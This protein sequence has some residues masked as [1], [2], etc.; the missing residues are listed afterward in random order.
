MPLVVAI[1]PSSFASQDR[2]PLD[3]LESIGAKIIPNPYSR[4]LTEEEIMLH[5]K[6]VDGLIAGLEP[7]NR[8]V[9]ASASRLKAIAR[10]GI[11]MENVDLDAARELGIKV[12]NTP[13]GPTQAVAEMTLAALLNLCRNII[14][15][16]TALHE[17]KWEKSISRGLINTK[18][19][20]VGYGRIGRTVGA[21][22]RSFG[23]S[24]L[25]TDPLLSAND[26]KKGEQLVS[27]DDGL[28]LAEV[29]S[30]HASGKDTILGS[31]EFN[32]MRDG[33]ILLNCARGELVN[34]PA[35]IKSLEYGKV[36][37][38]WCDVFAK[39]PYKGKLVKFNQVLLTPHISTYTQQCRK[40][41]ELSAVKN[42]LKDLGIN[43]NDETHSKL[44]KW[45]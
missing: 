8:A 31:K 30:L 34:E 41:M 4:R 29:I 33:V 21:L 26:L 22:L 15:Y 37:G 35:L 3:L 45:D 44:T 7:L 42:L 32:K 40:S 19:L 27:L 18:V 11:G 24:I 25:V 20:L 36:S 12:S 1:S 2:I 9:L 14:P 16:N 13:D 43:F 17:K 39:E 5:L 23:A 38:A 6:G 10:V 28:E